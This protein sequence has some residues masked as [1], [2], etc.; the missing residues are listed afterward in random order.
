MVMD[1]NHLINRYLEFYKSL[2]S[3]KR[4]PETKEQLRFV[5]VCR[6]K[7]LPK[8]EHEIAYINYKK[9]ISAKSN[10][11]YKVTKPKKL[12]KEQLRIIKSNHNYKP[13]TP[14]EIQEFRNRTV[15]NEE[16]IRKKTLKEALTQC[17]WI[18]AT[19]NVKYAEHQWFGE[20]GNQFLQ[21]NIFWVAQNIHAVNMLNRVLGNFK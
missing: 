10:I 18:T 17:S 11:Q 6:G 3:G 5:K 14:L 15:E 19:K 7:I 16:Y 8:T 4:K 21:L 1:S 12:T 2:D 20:K 9:M 13:R